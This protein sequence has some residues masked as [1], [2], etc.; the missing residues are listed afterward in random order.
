MRFYCSQLPLARNKLSL[1]LRERVG[2]RESQTFSQ[3]RVLRLAAKK[4]TGKS[5]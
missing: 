5:N 1:A 4:F 2:V 3:V